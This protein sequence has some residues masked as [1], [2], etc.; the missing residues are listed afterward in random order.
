M[1]A[2][3]VTIFSI[4]L[5]LGACSDK[6]NFNL[7]PPVIQPT[8]VKYNLTYLALGD[9]YTI[10][11]SVT[12]Y[13]AFPYQ[14]SAALKTDSVNVQ[15]PKIVARTGW[16]TSNLI[17]AIKGEDLKP[18]YD[19]VTLLIGVNNEYQGADIETYKIEF[20]QLLQTAIHF[21]G[22]NP[23]RVF[24]LSIPDWGVTPFAKNDSRSPATIAKEIDAYNAINKQQTADSDAN[25]LDITAISREAATDPTLLA[26]DGLHPSAQMY[27]RWI[28]LLAPMVKAK[29][30]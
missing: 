22:D 15:D 8:T 30:F 29:L 18:S 16:T 3:S 26:S 23:N 7:K 6:T 11:E 20:K 25:Y 10:G 1:K 4:L 12:T 21:A 5:S 24:V 9:S 19:F 28:A 13:G 14:L 17:D 27:A 2:L